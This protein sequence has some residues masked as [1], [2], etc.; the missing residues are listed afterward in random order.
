MVDDAMWREVRGAVLSWRKHYESSYVQVFG[1]D[2][3]APAPDGGPT[4]RLYAA[5]ELLAPRPVATPAMTVPPLA[6]DV[7]RYVT[8]PN[9]QRAQMEV[10]KRQS[11]LAA[12]FIETDLQDGNSAAPIRVDPESLRDV[13][14]AIEYRVLPSA[15]KLPQSPADAIR[16]FVQFGGLKGF[17]GDV[18][19]IN[20]MLATKVGPMQ[21]RAAVQVAANKG[22]FGQANQAALYLAQH[23]SLDASDVNP[24]PDN[25]TSPWMDVITEDRAMP[26]ALN[27]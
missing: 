1:T 9:F 10:R 25:S 21:I 2:A 3:P 22:Y 27:L 26:P 7:R 12:H 14:G 18:N 23:Y 19:E 15:P 4:A 8:G 5:S 24:Y 20:R 6:A 17:P 11:T 16:F 13:D